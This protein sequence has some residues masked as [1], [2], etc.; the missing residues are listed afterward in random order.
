[1]FFE[2]NK[3]V[4]KMQFIRSFEVG[5]YEIFCTGVIVSIVLNYQL[6]R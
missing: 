4:T 6:Q 5:K 2:S 3:L 1:M